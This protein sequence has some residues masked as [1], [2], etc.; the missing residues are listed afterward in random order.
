[1]AER[2]FI[3]SFLVG[4]CRVLLEEAPFSAAA[5]AGIESREQGNN[6][7]LLAVTIDPHDPVRTILASGQFEQFIGMPEDLFLEVKGKVP[8]DLATAS[9]RFELAKDVSAFAN[10]E[11]GHLL[12]GFI[13]EKLP[14]RRI[15]QIKELQMFASADLDLGQ[16]SGVLRTYVLPSIPGMTVSWV[17][18]VSNPKVGIASIYIPKQPDESKFFLITKLVEENE[19]QKEIVVGIARRAGGD[20]IPLRATEIYDLIRKGR[21]PVLQRT[22]RIEEKIDALSGERVTPA[23]PP[24][25]PAI[26]LGERLKDMR[27]L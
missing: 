5:L 6:G 8:Y 26:V 11:G 7:K 1:M 13:H 4:G 18:I 23:V 12:I 16:I 2:P 10:A 17:P 9:G 25:N 14:T 24:V 21:D 27:D 19:T 3:R 15:D 22:I 20:N